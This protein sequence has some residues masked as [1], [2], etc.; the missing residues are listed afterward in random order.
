MEIPPSRS[1]LGSFLEELMDMDRPSIRLDDG[2]GR[3]TLAWE[4]P[5]C[6]SSLRRNTPLLLACGFLL[7]QGGPVGRPAGW[8][9]QRR[10]Q[11]WGG[12]LGA[13]GRAGSL[14]LSV[15]LVLV[16]DRGAPPL[17]GGSP[18]FWWVSPPPP[19]GG[20]LLHSVCPWGSAL[21]E[22]NPKQG[23]W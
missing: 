18:L 9:C 17:S 19:S 11:G 5:H 15:W 16:K 20:L 3:Q 7:N 1:L 14:L 13:R 6:L 23:T 2:P 22:G 4:M 8:D 21:G 12:T 10:G